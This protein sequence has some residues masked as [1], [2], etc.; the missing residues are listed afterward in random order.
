M[1]RLMAFC[2]IMGA[3]LMINVQTLM[4]PEIDTSAH[5]PKRPLLI[6]LQRESVPVVRH[7]VTVSHKT[8]YSGLISIGK[9]AQEF[10]VVFDTGSAHIVVPSAD[11]MNA[12]CREHQQYNVRASSTGVAING[13]GSPVPDDE[14]CDQVTIGYGTGKVKGEFVRDQVC[15]GAANSQEDSACIE[16]SVVTAVEMTNSPFRSFNFD[17]IFGLAL[18]SLAMTPEFNFMDR[19]AGSTGHVSQQFGVFL[20]DGEHGEE[21]EIALGGH[22]TERLLTPLDWVPIARPELG[23]WQISIKEI[24]IQ[25]KPLETCADGTCRAIVDTGTSHVGV[26]G[27]E[28]RSFV[29]LLSADAPDRTTDCR[30][31]EGADLEFV[32]ETDIAVKVSP[33]DYMRPLPLPAGTNVGMS[34]G[35]PVLVGNV[36]NTTGTTSRP[37][38]STEGE[39]QVA[40]PKPRICTPR[41]MPVNLAAPLG[42]KLFI[43]GEPVLQKY[44]TVYDA[45]QKKV[46]FG[47]AANNH[48]RKA[49][50]LD[51]VQDETTLVLMQVSMKVRVRSR[52]LAC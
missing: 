13:D 25:G 1:K 26:P 35:K 36:S 28:L 29:N 34:S 33:G 40:A 47:L 37:T 32:L 50:G 21:S 46:A 5:T 8:S 6:P 30:Q 41:L 3:S 45:A 20:T 10:R 44:Y 51:A 12:T 17:G 2:G 49:T 18:A 43:L 15:P 39:M 11:C 7:N 27:P 16:V 31:V 48:N 38:A 24:R 22:N 4:V 14:L 9:P 19:L 52:K 23:Y 42:P